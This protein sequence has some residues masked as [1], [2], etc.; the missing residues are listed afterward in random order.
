MRVRKVLPVV[1]ILGL[2]GA[3]GAVTWS[4][5]SRPADTFMTE[6]TARA[7]NLQTG[8]AP[9]RASSPMAP[10]ETLRDAVAAAPPPASSLMKPIADPGMVV[11]AAPKGG[12]DRRYTEITPKAEAWARKHRLLAGLLAKPAK[13]MIARS[14]MGSPRELRAFLA[15]PRKVDAYMNSSLVRVA[16]NSPTVAKAILGNPEVIRAFL[17]SPAMRDPKAARALLGSPML[18]KMLDCPAIQEAVGDP[19]VMRRMFTDPQTVRWLAAH[20]ETMS[21]ITAAVPAF[22]ARAG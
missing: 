20:P 22:G 6:E 7:F 8:P 3:G 17:A 12:M 11:G 5:M 21:A 4:V 10:G 14:A 13:F 1:S 15:D 18:R 2:L 9:A 16:I 19:V